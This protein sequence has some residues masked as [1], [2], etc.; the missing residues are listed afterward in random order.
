MLSFLWSL[1]EVLVWSTWQIILILFALGV[2]RGWLMKKGEEKDA[3]E[4]TDD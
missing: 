2:Y 4:S 1:I 3:T